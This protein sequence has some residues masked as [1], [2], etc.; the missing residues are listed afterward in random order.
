M[1]VTLR[2]FRTYDVRVTFIHLESV[3]HAFDYLPVSCGV[4]RH[5]TF[6]AAVVYYKTLIL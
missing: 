6:V 3:I 4:V 2:P 5:T 1:G